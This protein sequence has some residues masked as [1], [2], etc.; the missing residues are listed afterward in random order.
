MI[1]YVKNYER[2][3]FMTQF[4]EKHQRLLKIYCII[5]RIIGWYLLGAGIF[6]FVVLVHPYSPP[7]Q[8]PKPH[9]ILYAA[10][11]TICDFIIPAFLAFSIADFLDYLLDSRTK[12]RFLLRATD[13]LCYAYA[14]F[15]ALNY[16]TAN[17]WLT[18]TNFFNILGLSD[19]NLFVFFQ[20]LLGPT[21]AK[22][23]MLIC[24]A[25]VLRRLLPVIEESK[26]LV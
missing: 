26:T 24:V 4:I 25:I 3:S 22:A 7:G 20:P 14:A 19:S 11:R 15:L 12:P 2:R 9:L 5:A 8:Q 18:N 17:L 6:Y 23:I 13:K 1:G 10:F 21:L 16:L